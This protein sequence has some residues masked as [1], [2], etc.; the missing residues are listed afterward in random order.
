MKWII[1]RNRS[2]TPEDLRLCEWARYIW[3]EEKVAN[4]TADYD[5]DYEDTPLRSQEKQHII[6]T[7]N[8]DLYVDVLVG[9]LALVPKL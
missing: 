3:Q 8:Y 2:E 4:R 6:Y 1:K 5:I 9:L 7:N